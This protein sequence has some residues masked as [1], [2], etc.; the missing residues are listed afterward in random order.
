MS[1]PPHRCGG[2]RRILSVVPW[3]VAALLP[4]SFALAEPCKRKT[5][6]R[7]IGICMHPHGAGVN[8]WTYD[9][10]GHPA[11]GRMAEVF[12]ACHE[13]LPLFTFDPNADPKN[14][15]LLPIEYRGRACEPAPP[16]PSPH[17]LPCVEAC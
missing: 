7:R 10:S 1:Y 8:A 2:S 6:I 15:D 14:R 12:L 16:N 17:P 9:L 3:L 5:P 13:V 11:T 4:P